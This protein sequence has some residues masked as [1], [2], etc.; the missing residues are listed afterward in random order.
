M[1]ACAASNRGPVTLSG[2]SLIA[3]EPTA[4]TDGTF[5]A[6]GTLAHFEEASGEHVDRAVEAAAP[7]CGAYRGRSADTRAAFLD[8][9][10]LEIEASDELLAAA[11]VETALPM[12]RLAGE[13]T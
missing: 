5:T 9:I 2:K 13:R 4:S 10:A 7:A 8:R 11:H 1:P 12:P 6:S 3:G